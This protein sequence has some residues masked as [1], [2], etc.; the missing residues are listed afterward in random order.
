MENSWY[1]A[2][3]KTGG[4]LLQVRGRLARREREKERERE[5]ENMHKL[6]GG[7][8]LQSKFLLK[9]SYFDF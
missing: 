9:F 5:R 2:A 6:V 3:G 1:P 8:N 4:G 7:E